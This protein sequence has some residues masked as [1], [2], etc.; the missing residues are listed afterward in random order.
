MQRCNEDYEPTNT[1]LAVDA[2]NTTTG[3]DGHTTDAAGGADT[4][5]QR[6]DNGPTNL[7]HLPCLYTLGPKRAALSN[8]WPLTC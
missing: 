6:Q 8:E 7:L 2:A 1:V 5:D 3:V 4:V